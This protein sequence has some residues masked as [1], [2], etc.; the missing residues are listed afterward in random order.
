MD[1]TTVSAYLKATQ[2]YAGVV[3]HERSKGKRIHNMVLSVL[4]ELAHRLDVRLCRVKSEISFSMKRYEAL[5]FLSAYEYGYLPT[6]V[7]PIQEIVTIIDKQ[8]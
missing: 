7:I 3:P 5:A 2:N 1:W 6:G 8:E 4:G